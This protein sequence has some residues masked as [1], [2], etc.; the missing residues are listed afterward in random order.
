MKR[1]M[2]FFMCL[3]FITVWTIPAFAGTTEEDLLLSIKPRIGDTSCYAEVKS[4]KTETEG[5]ISMRYYWSAENSSL[6]VCVNDELVI[7]QY[8]KYQWDNED[9]EMNVFER[10]SW[11]ELT[12]YAYGEAKRLNPDLE[13]EIIP[14]DGVMSLYSNTVS[15]NIQRQKDGIPVIGDTGYLQLSVLDMTVTHFSINYTEKIQFESADGLIS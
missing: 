5:A 1:M 10:P 12:A 7:T 4:D 6:S 13:I 2:T 15:F 3:V 14:Q 9:A 8:D 11:D